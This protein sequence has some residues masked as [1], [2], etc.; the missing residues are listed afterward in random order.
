MIEPT[1]LLRTDVASVPTGGLVDVHVHLAA[2]DGPGLRL[3]E[4]SH[5]A[6]ETGIRCAA[7]FPPRRTD[8]YA[9]ANDAILTTVETGTRRLRRFARL[10]GVLAVNRAA[11][12]PPSLHQVRS[13]ARSRRSSPPPDL[14]LDGTPLS[15]DASTPEFVSALRGFDGVNLL[16]HVDGFPPANA[17]A[18]IA[19]LGLP[20]V[21]HGG[22]RMPPSVL[23]QRLV[24]E[25]SGPV[26]LAH[27]GAYPAS[28]PDFTDALDLARR[29]ERVY[30]STSGTW[31]AEFVAEA[32][33]SVPEKVMFGSCSPLLHPLVAWRQVAAAV[34][35]D[36]TLAS[37]GAGNAERVLGW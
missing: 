15:A 16:P 12:W 22:E 34:S 23:E 20:V 25:V 13:L 7:V 19:E 32:A 10:G 5:L 8:G 24:K 4:F 17:L 11:L 33:R 2:D 35:D 26:I 28:A 36:E 30:L 31:L 21:V 3:S 9:Q 1:H 29:H 37:I 14:L 27:L 6:E 18:A